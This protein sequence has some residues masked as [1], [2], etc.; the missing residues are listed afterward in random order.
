MPRKSARDNPIASESCQTNMRP[1]QVKTM[2]RPTLT[3]VGQARPLNCIFAIT[4]LVIAGYTAENATLEVTGK[5]SA[6]SKLVYS[7]SVTVPAWGEWSFAGIRAPANTANEAIAWLLCS[8]WTTVVW[9]AGN[10]RRKIE[11]PL[12]LLTALLGAVA[13][14][15][16]GDLNA[17]VVMPLSVTVTAIMLNASN[18]GSPSGN[19]SG[20]KIRL[21][22]KSGLKPIGTALMLGVLTLAGVMAVWRTGFADA[23]DPV[24]VRIPSYALATVVAAAVAYVIACRTRNRRTLGGALMAATFA[25]AWY[26]GP[27]PMGFRSAWE[28]R[29]H[30]VVRLTESKDWRELRQEL[31]ETRLSEAE[32]SVQ[33]MP[34]PETATQWARRQTLGTTAGGLGDE[35]GAL[36]GWLATDEALFAGTTGAEQERSRATAKTRREAMPAGP[37]AAETAGWPALDAGDYARAA[38]DFRRALEAQPAAPM[39]WL[40]LALAEAGAGHEDAATQAL[41]HW[42]LIDPRAVFSPAWNRAPLDRLRPESMRRWKVSI[43]KLSAD[44]ALSANDAARLHRFE[45]WLSAWERAGGDVAKFLDDTSAPVPPA[46]AVRLVRERT[47][48]TLREP[49][50]AKIGAII[51]AGTA[52]LANRHVNLGQCHEIFN[53]MRDG[54]TGTNG[55]KATIMISRP[56]MPD[57]PETCRITEGGA[58]ATLHDFEENLVVRLLTYGHES[59]HIQIPDKFLREALPK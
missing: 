28:A 49:T 3:S 37:I 55:A 36:A 42:C 13:C 57:W 1:L 9:L 10:S 33:R 15:G 45:G 59:A 58:G 8:G 18:A 2:P 24:S 26:T 47:R 44:D 39:R 6:W 23:G 32:A 7:L 53:A 27:G 40:G 51:S 21:L 12:W 43:E 11:R 4:A 46:G 54:K 17:V 14:I 30:E 50:D 48:D 16:A 22:S 29:R 41:A 5:W 34:R 35:G 52:L 19:E 25:A 56:L 31:E 20:D 38:A